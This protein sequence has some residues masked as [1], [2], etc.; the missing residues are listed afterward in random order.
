M[1]LYM[2]KGNDALKAQDLKSAQKFF[3]M[4]ETELTKLEKFLGH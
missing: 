2:A 4:A 3:D 1:Q